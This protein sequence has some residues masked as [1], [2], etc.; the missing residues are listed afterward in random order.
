V[1]LNGRVMR[2]YGKSRRELFEYLERDKL[3]PLS[4]TR[5]EYADWIKAFGEDRRRAGALRA[6][7][8]RVGA[9]I[10]ASRS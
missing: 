8:R 6:E 5:F 9:S 2:R 1:D 7:H 4:N 3:R 10:Q